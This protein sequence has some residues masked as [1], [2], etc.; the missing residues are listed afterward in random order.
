MS[1]QNRSEGF[2]SFS[3]WVHF[4]PSSIV[5]FSSGVRGRLSAS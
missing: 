5:S 2:W 3:H 4:S 1:M